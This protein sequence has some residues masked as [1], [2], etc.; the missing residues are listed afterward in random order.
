MEKAELKFLLSMATSRAPSTHVLVKDRIPPIRP[1][2]AVVAS[3][4]AYSVVCN[5]E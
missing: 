5:P 3:Q 1:A 2:A 4:A